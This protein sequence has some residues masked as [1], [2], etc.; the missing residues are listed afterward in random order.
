MNPLLSV[1]IPVYNGV[2]YLEEALLSV[3]NQTY[4]PLEIILIDDGSTDNPKVVADKFSEVKYFYQEHGGLPKARNYGIEKA[5]GEF[6]GFHDAD[7]IC[8]LDRFEKQMNLLIE[9]PNVGVCFTQIQNFVQE[10]QNVR[11]ELRTEELLKP[12][13]GFIS[14]AVI[15]RNTFD[16]TGVFNEKFIH[17]EDMEWL[18]RAQDKA[19]VCAVVNEVLIKRRLHEKNNSADIKTEHQYLMQA[20]RNSIRNKKQ[21]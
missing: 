8:Y 12:R 11:E 3:I 7:D 19:V 1:I 21:E 17:A 15:R 10:N 14:S 9:N 20:L 18:I 16:T 2:E 5:K 6:I 4:Q 13:M